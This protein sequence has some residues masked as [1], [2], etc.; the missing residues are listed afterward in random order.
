MLPNLDEAAATCDPVVGGQVEKHHF[1]RG[2]WLWFSTGFE[3]GR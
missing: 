2:R 1:D 3:E